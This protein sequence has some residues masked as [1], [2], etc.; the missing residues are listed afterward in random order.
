M[1]Q[2]LLPV[3]PSPAK[4]LVYTNLKTALMGAILPQ[5]RAE[6][7][8]RIIPITV[9]TGAALVAVHAGAEAGADACAR[10]AYKPL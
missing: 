1:A 6:S 9:T 2:A 3:R 5:D 4:L 7:A 10:S 8:R